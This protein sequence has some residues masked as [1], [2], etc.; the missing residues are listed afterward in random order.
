METCTPNG[1]VTLYATPKERIRLLQNITSSFGK[2]FS[3]DKYINLII[4]KKELGGVCIGECIEN[5]IQE[6]MKQ[7]LLCAEELL[8]IA[9]KVV[10]KLVEEGLVA[11]KLWHSNYFPG[12]LYSY[13]S[14]KRN[15]ASGLSCRI[16]YIPKTNEKKIPGGIW[17]RTFPIVVEYGIPKET[18]EC[19]QTNG[20]TKDISWL[21]YS[22]KF[23]LSPR[24]DFSLDLLTPFIKDWKKYASGWN[25]YFEEEP[26][27]QNKIP[28]LRI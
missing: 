16:K 21:S 10:M 26:E 15:Q 2:L 13:H 6:R 17:K 12:I 22:P 18:R 9:E 7:Y 25:N 4:N 14:D 24:I 23:W 3:E 19:I 11:P 1:M 8:S 5:T 28:E 20:K 27:I